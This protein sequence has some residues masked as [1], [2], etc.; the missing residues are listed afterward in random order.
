MRLLPRSA[1]GTWLLAGAVWLAGC[2]I[3]W[4]L[5]PGVPRVVVP[6]TNAGSMDAFTA[7]GRSICGQIYES[8]DPASQH[9]R[10]PTIDGMAAIGPFRVWDLETGLPLA[11]WPKPIGVTVHKEFPKFAVALISDNGP[12]GQPLYLLDIR[13]G[14]RE[15]LP[16]KTPASKKTYLTAGGR[17][18]VYV[19]DLPASDSACWW[20]RN[21]HEMVGTYS[22]LVPTAIASNGQWLTEVP[23]DKDGDSNRFTV[24]EPATARELT[25]AELAEEYSR[26]WLAADGA[27][28]FVQAGSQVHVIELASGR[29]CVPSLPLEAFAVLPK[30][31]Q[32]LSLDRTDN[33]R[34]LVRWD[35]DTGR[36][37]G[38]S[39][40]PSNFDPIYN[41]DIGD[42]YL[43]FVGYPDAGPLTSVKKYLANVPILGE[44][45]TSESME[46]AIIDPVNGLEVARIRPSNLGRAELSPDGR[47]LVCI[48]V[49]GRL[50][51]WDIPPRKPLT[52]FALTTAVLAL[53]LAGMAWRRSRRLRKEAA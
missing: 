47:T 36:E 3:V 4:L 29:R 11:T 27:F 13:T 17:Y 51:F 19:E 23:A 50:E 5:L 45:L 46:C 30:A 25:H 41:P 2:L 7:D 33:P 40:T 39:R 32:V 16:W 20:D 1:K 10:G 24:R 37:I 49:D 28:L 44:I 38:R 35:L 6:F 26:A 43:L 9:P 15:L 8:F 42:R 48:T 21:T 18:L 53:P 12:D 52:W 22:G 31:R 34:W 14:R